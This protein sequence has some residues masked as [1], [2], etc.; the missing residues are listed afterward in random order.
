MDERKEAGGGERMNDTAD[1]GGTT[2][3]H[4]IGLKVLNG[5]FEISKPV[6]NEYNKGGMDGLLAENPTNFTHANPSMENSYMVDEHLDDIAPQDDPSN[7]RDREAGNPLTFAKVVQQEKKSVKVN[8]RHME[9]SDKVDGV[10]VVI[11]LS[12]VKEVNDRFANTL[13]GYFLGKRLAYPVVDYFVK[14]NWAK[15]GLSRLMMNAKGFFFFFK[16]NTKSGMDQLL[17]DGPWMIKNVPI[18]LNEW[19]PSVSVVKEDTTSVPVWV[20]MHDVPLPAFTEDGLSLLAS[21]VGVPKRLDSYTAKMCV[22]SWGRSSFVRALIEIQAGMELKRNVMVAVP[23]LDGKGYTKMEVK[24]EYDWEPLRCSTCCVFGHNDNSCP[25]NPKPANDE[26]NRNND[27]FQDVK[28]KNKK[29]DQHGFHVKNQKSKLVYRPVVKPK[30][31][32]NMASSSNVPVRNSFDV[33]Q[34][35]SGAQE[36]PTVE[37]L[38]KQQMVNPIGEKGGTEEVVVDDI[39]VDDM[40]HDYVEGHDSKKKN[41]KSEGSS[42][43]GRMG[44]NG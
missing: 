19:S 43:P 5:F 16:F 21:K 28:G 12:S 2:P 44:F 4:G 33:L 24:I 15:Y 8:F 23:A 14:N 34:D 7:H 36:I 3:M 40:L 39:D 9:S 37:R 13:Y 35:E 10:D 1:D 11:P 32:E 38:E 25:K 27:G 30:L 20:K 42:T 31:V 18:I 29:A 26:V 22:E 6:G 17:E 41:N